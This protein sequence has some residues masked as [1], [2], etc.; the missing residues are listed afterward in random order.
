MASVKI[1]RRVLKIIENKISDVFDSIKGKFL[2]PNV[3]KTLYLTYNKDLS[4]PGMYEAA[5]REEG[6]I[7]Q[8]ETL[9]KLTDKSKNYLDALKSRTIN[10]IVNKL[11]SHVKEEQSVSVESVSAALKETLGQATSE[12]KRIIETETQVAKNVGLLDGI[13]RSNSSMGID[14]PVICFIPAKDKEVCDECVKVH[15]M[16]D[17]ATPRVWRL[18]EVSGGY[19]IKGEDRPS[20]SGLHP[21]CRCVMVTLFPGFG[22]KNGR[23]SFI[24]TNHD[25][26]AAQRR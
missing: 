19:H 9:D 13:V 18:S 26:L 20:L 15:Y 14:D 5:S 12:L 6:G 21:N 1:P 16:P 7:P 10:K 22:F 24:S 4:L 23:V 11:E 17:G 25:E 2:G 3:G 8:I